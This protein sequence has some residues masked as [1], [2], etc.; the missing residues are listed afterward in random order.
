MPSA[1][2]S[3]SGTHAPRAAPSKRRI[4]ARCVSPKAG[5]PRGGLRVLIGLPPKMPRAIQRSNAERLAAFRVG[6][7]Y[8]LSF[9]AEAPRPSRCVTLRAGVHENRT[10]EAVMLERP[11][12][13]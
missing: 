11:R 13:E 1:R 6:R 12:S 3:G 8:G 2:I 10:L 9:P 4:A 5:R 7:A